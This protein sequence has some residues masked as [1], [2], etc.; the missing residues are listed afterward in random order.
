MEE[1]LETAR[2]VWQRYLSG[3]TKAGIAKALSIH[4]NEVQSI[5]KYTTQTLYFDER[6]QKKKEQK[7]VDGIITKA[8]KIIAKKKAEIKALKKKLG[9]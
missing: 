3:E 6:E 7:R 4:R 2:S 9:E 8:N 5:I 1:Q